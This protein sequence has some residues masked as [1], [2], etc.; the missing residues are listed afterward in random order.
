MSV[1]SYSVRIVRAFVWFEVQEQRLRSFN[2]A[3]PDNSVTETMHINQRNFVFHGHRAHDVGI[4]SVR[5][6]RIPI[7]I[8]PAPHHRRKQN[9]LCVPR[10]HIGY[11]PNKIRSIIIR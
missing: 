8:K 7:L 2:T 5:V 4:N 3:F 6:V 9:R 10:A 11:E 1:V